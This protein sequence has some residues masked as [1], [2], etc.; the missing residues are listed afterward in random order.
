M[1]LSDLD[2]LLSIWTICYQ[3]G[4]S[5]LNVFLLRKMDNLLSIY[6]YFITLVAF[7]WLLSTVHFQMLPQIAC[8]RRR[9][10]TLVALTFL[11]C[12]FSNSNYLCLS[13]HSHIDCTCLIFLHCAFSNVSKDRQS[14]IVCIC[15]TFLHCAFSK[16]F[17]NSLDEKRQS[18][19]VC[20][21][22]TFLHCV[23]SNAFSKH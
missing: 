18:H 8:L 1:Q 13:M 19:I 17:S 6:I 7:V 9:I 16:V 2:N 14:H 23:F 15:L 20:I 10:V 5:Y 4:E 3:F 12:V 11:C 21:C 22:L